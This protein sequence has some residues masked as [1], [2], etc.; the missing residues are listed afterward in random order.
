MG[1]KEL[2][3]KLT[4]Y[5]YLY[6]KGKIKKSQVDKVYDNLQE[7]IKIRE[8]QKVTL[9]G[10]PPELPNNCCAPAPV[11]PETGMH[12]DYWV[13]S[14]A[15]R[16]KGFIRPVRYVYLHE[17]CGTTTRMGTAL[18]ETYA[19][20]PKFYGATFCCFCK[21]HFPVGIN[22]EFLWEGTDEKVGT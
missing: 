14:E 3:Q 1:L 15:E 18:A 8:T 11:D 16:A 7:Q 21:N 4:D 12:K 6:G 13:L 9:S 20:D 19:R 17:K 2:I 10:N 22:G 5:A